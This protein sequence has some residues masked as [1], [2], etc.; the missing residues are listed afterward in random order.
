MVPGLFIGATSGY[1]GKNTMLMGIGLR[2]MR[3][4]INL[5][6]MKPV[7]LNLVKH[8]GQQGDEDAVFVQEVLGLSENPEDVT[9]I[10][11]TQDFKVQAFQSGVEDQLPKIKKSYEKLAQNKELMLLGGSGNMF[12]ARYCNL[13]AMRLV[14]EM[15]WKVLVVERFSNALKYD[16]LTVYKD[17]LKDQM[18]GVILNDIP[19]IFMSEVEGLIKPYLE[20][21]GIPVLGI[22]PK[23][24]LMSSISVS[25]L[26]ESLSARVISA[27]ERCSTMI[28]NFLIGSMQ[29]ENFM[30][31]LRRHKKAAVIVGGDRA[32]IQLVALE[33]GCPC[34]VLTGNIYPN[35]IILSRADA[36]GIPILLVREDTYS[37]ANKMEQVLFRHKLRDPIKVRQ[38]AQ[39]VAG[40]LNFIAIK[41]ALGLR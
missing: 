16:L 7:G 32:D 23:D 3:E 14:K 38:G 41:E 9:P 1:A 10:V 25:D 22:V 29:V 18:L 20:R 24:Q 40:S 15:G 26:T 4:N 2:L 19:N 21:S 28:E 5:G 35:D 13:D 31:Y 37:V 30:A 34:L 39:L 36:L 6:Y 12:T 33:S 8:N 17:M 11:V 27:Q